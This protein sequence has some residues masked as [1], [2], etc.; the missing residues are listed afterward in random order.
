[1]TVGFTTGLLHDALRTD[2]DGIGPRPISWAAWYPTSP[3][4]A[5]APMRG[6]GPGEPWFDM[7][8]VARDAPLA[9][10]GRT[11]PVVVVS[12]GTG[13]TAVSLGWLARRLA[14][15][16]FLV[17]AADHHGN[18]AIEPYRAEGFLCWWERARDLSVLLDVLPAEARFAG[19]LDTERVFAVGFSL[20]CHTALSLL[21]AITDMDRFRQWAEQAGGPLSRG[22]REF[23]NLS[24]HFPK[25]L[26]ESRP[27]QASWARRSASY[28]DPRLRAALLLAPAPPVRAFTDDSLAAVE[29][30]VYMMVGDADGEAPSQ[31]GAEWLAMR[32]PMVDLQ[33]LGPSVGHFVFLPEST[34]AGRR[35]R[36]DL[37]VDAPG[38]D[39]RAVHD[40]AATAAM[41][42]FEATPP[43]NDTPSR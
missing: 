14:A 18:T 32:L 37:C 5:E 41:R 24:D 15:N 16:G 12:H 20:G 38:V 19:R 27:L 22:P 11:L 28:R 43:S 3:D 35:D 17:L 42:L 39:R 33:R 4:A 8:A 7:G 36:P 23:P 40:G 21:G 1:M 31:V 26:A 34:A 6:G 9:P 10:P 29:R 25:L 13:G 2:W 30:P